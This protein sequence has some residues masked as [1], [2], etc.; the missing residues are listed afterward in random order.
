M[1][2][3]TILWGDIVFYDKYIQLCKE[4][5]IAPTRAAIEAGFSK[6]LVTKWDK[7]GV[8][9][10]SAEI[11]VKIS[12][13]FDIPISE[14]MGEDRKEKV[15]ESNNGGVE[16]ESL[17]E[18]NRIA[19]KCSEKDRLMLLDIMRSVLARRGDS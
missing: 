4:R 10:P 3:C 17:A 7:K 1:S 6:S 18:I 14:L 16:S 8:E 15:K 5:D 13:Y 12:K 2:L 11:A 19:E 9:F